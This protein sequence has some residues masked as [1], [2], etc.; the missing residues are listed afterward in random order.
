[1]HFLIATA[2]DE[3]SDQAVRL[4]AQLACHARATITIMTVAAHESDRAQADAV[5]T[6]T[7]TLVNLEAVNVKTKVCVGEVV[8][9]IA[10]EAE[11]ANYDLLIIGSQPDHGILTRLTGP[12]SERILAHSPRPVLIVKGETGSFHK[13]LVCSSGAN[14][15][16]G[17]SRSAIRLSPILS[18]TTITLLHVMSQISASLDAR[19]GWQ[20]QATADELIEEESPEG[21]LLEERLSML[22]NSGFQVEAKVRHGLVVDEILDELSSGNYDLIVIGAHS[23]SGWKRYLLDDVA[24]QIITRADRPV[25]VV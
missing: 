14:G 20:L 7:L 2:G 15:Y 3:H 10:R 11:T 13:I 23:A 21:Q 25:L 5:L 19:D 24:H 6:R 12:T 8:A 9:E 16:D 17:P 22:E 18:G 4:G 1:M